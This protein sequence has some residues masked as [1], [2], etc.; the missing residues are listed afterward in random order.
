MAE[1]AAKILAHEMYALC[2]ELFPI[3]RS[4][5][6]DGFRKSLSILARHIEGL[7]VHEVA[8]GTRC[9]DWQVPQ[10]WNIKDAYIIAPNG[11]KICNFK[12]SNLHVMGYSTPIDR[13]MTLTELQKNLHSLPDQP[14]A[15]PYLTSYYHERWGFCISQEQRDQLQEGNYHV[16][17]DSELKE[18]SLTYGEI[19]LP[20]RSDK[21]IFL[22]TYLCHP[23]MANNELSGPVVTSYL[24]KW[25][26]QLKNRKYSYRI[27]IIPETI[28][29]ITYLSRHYKEMQKKV[30]AGFNITCIGDDKTYSYLSSR[31]GN[32]L[33]DQ[34]ILHVL[35]HKHPRFKSYSFLDKGSDERQYCSP[36]IDLPVC[37]VMRSKYGC[38][39]EYHTS[40][41][42]MS[43]I[44][45]EGLFGGYDV[46]KTAVECLEMNA[47]LSPSVMCEPQL[48]K[49]GLYPSISSKKTAAQVRNMMNFIAYCDGKL[50]ALEIAEI[51]GVPLWDL[52]DTLMKLVDK[53]VLDFPEND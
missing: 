11:E 17:I 31:K 20:G 26:A 3:C 53:N 48:G 19:I 25:L 29:S 37:S 8:S 22:S 18:G 42:D 13:L 35:K 16:F 40:L 15:I 47:V 32:T 10:E 7:K 9:F 14:T 44:S 5:T 46:I 27:I 30:I 39:P 43:F 50:S 51:I 38:Y 34:V 12:D 6:G 41:D 36:G 23:S 45:P 24:A 33:A 52:K 1:N 28:G 2:A 21:E 4:I 49:R